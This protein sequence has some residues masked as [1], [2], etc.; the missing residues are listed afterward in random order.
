MCTHQKDGITMTSTPQERS[1]A[2]FVPA[3]SKSP[4]GISETTGYPPSGSGST[5]K[6]SSSQES[7]V[8]IYH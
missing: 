6:L 8:C 2:V 7:A 1:P 3:N 4:A 5:V